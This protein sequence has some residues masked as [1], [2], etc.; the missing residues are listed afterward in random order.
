MYI[1]N[2]ALERLESRF[3][4]SNADIT[5]I[6]SILKNRKAYRIM[7]NKSDGEHR[8]FNY[9]GQC[10]VAVCKENMVVTFKYKDSAYNKIK[11]NE[12]MKRL[13]T[14]KTMTVKEVAESLRTPIRTVHNAID[15]C[16]PNLKE[17]GKTTYLTNQQ[18][19]EISKELKKAHNV[20]LASTRKVAVT[21][22]ELLDRSRD[23]IFDLTSRVKQLHDEN[24][25]LK[26]KAQFYD[27]VAGSKDAIDMG[28]AAK[29]L[30]M[31]IGR[32][33]LFELL[34]DE[35]VLMHNNQPYQKYVDNGYFR[36]IEQKFIKTDGT[37]SIN[38]KTVVYQK[39]LD[40][41][42]KLIE[43]RK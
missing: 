3:H 16:F 12:R 23:L 43:R 5:N 26:P 21:D 2:H 24:Q 19:T 31:G 14:E 11:E 40:F 32:N 6:L 37:T 36:T 9:N 33:K 7:T 17:N 8:R 35:K 41:I 10:L 39:G 20:D 29:V 34:R 13:S 27:Q 1:T 15:R 18:V 38:I 30:N 22:L 4:Y 28:S 42:R 25:E